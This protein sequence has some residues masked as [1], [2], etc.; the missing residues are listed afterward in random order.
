MHSVVDPG[1]SFEGEGPKHVVG[2]WRQIQNLHVGFR[3]RPRIFHVD[4][5]SRLEFQVSFESRPGSDKGN[6]P[7]NQVCGSTLTSL[8]A[9]AKETTLCDHSIL[10]TLTNW[11]H[12][13]IHVMNYIYCCIRFWKKY[14]LEEIIKWYC[15]HGVQ[16]TS[17]D[18]LLLY[19]N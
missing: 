4:F 11:S 10:L 12:I 2:F 9:S 16:L 5:G 17:T 13:S 8:H 3:G 19:W 7:L 18:R 14:N 15:N 6:F 1:F